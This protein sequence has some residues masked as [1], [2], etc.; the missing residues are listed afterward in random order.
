MKY[1]INILRGPTEGI[2]RFRVPGVSVQT[3]CWWDPEV[4]V[5]PGV[6]LNCAATHMTN[7]KDTVTGQPRPGIWLGMQVPVNEGQR[8]ARGIFI[9]EGKNA[10]W[11]DGCIIIRREEV[12]K[13]FNALPFDERV[14]TVRVSN[15]EDERRGGGKRPG[16]GAPGKDRKPKQPTHHTMHDLA[17]QLKW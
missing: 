9:H 2:L 17:N 6:Y 15:R 7:K 12:L 10:G 13:I 4:V 1:I 5:D 14:A 3:P 8:Q 16:R 11:S